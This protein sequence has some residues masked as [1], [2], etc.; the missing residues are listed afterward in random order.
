MRSIMVFAAVLASFIFS[1]RAFAGAQATYNFGI[2][3]FVE[4][5][6][7]PIIYGTVPSLNSVVV[8][9]A[10]TLQ[11]TNTIPIGAN[12][13]GITISPD[14]STVYVANTG[15]S[16]IA[17]LNTSTLTTLSPLVSPGG[18][19]AQLQFGNS[20]RLWVL[21]GGI[22]QID[23]TT[24]ASAGPDLSTTNG[25]YPLLLSGGNIVV[26]P[27]GNSLYYGNYGLSP[28]NAYK[29]DVSTP[30]SPHETWVIGG[31]GNGQAVALSHGGGLF[32]YSSGGDS[33]LALLNPSQQTV[34][35]VNSRGSAIAFSADDKYVYTAINFTG[36]VN[37]WDLTTFLQVGS[38]IPT[39]G[40]P[41]VM[42]T[43]TSGAHLFVGEGSVTQVFAAPEP[44]TGSALLIAGVAMLARRRK[45]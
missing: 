14:G 9:N 4:S 18:N 16:F 38:S 33:N 3:E 17:R 30:S 32:A 43:D 40:E 12:P 27:D 39:A 6:T 25:M 1:R 19:P 44:A 10:N 13:L 36:A 26:S 11:V 29:Y 8:I 28:S 31:G 42:F 20:N 15:S 22:H 41:G 37:K 5:P 7:Q 34:G 21:N 35:T 23:A 2:A 24:G 45:H